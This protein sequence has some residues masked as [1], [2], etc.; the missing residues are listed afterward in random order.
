[1]GYKLYAIRERDTDESEYK[2]FIT[3]GNSIDE[4]IE[5]V[6]QHINDYKENTLTFVIYKDDEEV[7]IIY[8][9]YNTIIVLNKYKKE[10]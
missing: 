7:F 10:E 9:H 3:T 2:E 4:L 8:K 5:Y 6:K 1:M